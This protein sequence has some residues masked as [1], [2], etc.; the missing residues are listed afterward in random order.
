MALRPAPRHGA[1]IRLAGADMLLHKIIEAEEDPIDLDGVRLGLLF[2][3]R[4][5]LCH[6]VVGGLEC[7]GT[8]IR[9]GSGTA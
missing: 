2:T 4:K 3:M 6:R 1:I 8:A 5:N 7:A 9:L